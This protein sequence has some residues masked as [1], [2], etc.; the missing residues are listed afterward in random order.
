MGLISEIQG[1]CG[2]RYLQK[3]EGIVK[4]YLLHYKS[5]ERIA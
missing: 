5:E 3:I 1:S 2:M 4:L